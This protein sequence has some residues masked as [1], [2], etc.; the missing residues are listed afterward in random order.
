MTGAASDAKIGTPGFCY[1]CPYWTGGAG[2]IGRCRRNPPS[3][4]VGARALWPM[5]DPTEWC[6]E[7]PARQNKP[8]SEAQPGP[9]IRPAP[10]KRR[11][12]K[13]A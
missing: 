3:A 6:G 10:A 5:T 1:S 8:A 12:R 7:H 2:V 13:A 9:A 4:A 11:T